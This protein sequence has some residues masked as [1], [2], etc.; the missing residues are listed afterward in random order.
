M[1]RVARRSGAWNTD[2]VNT[3][4]H[5]ILSAAVFA[6]TDRRRVNAAALAGGMLPDLSLY[7][8]G[9]WMMTIGGQSPELFFGTTYYSDWVQ[10]VMSVD[11]SIPL[12]SLAVLFALL[13]RTPAA[14][15]FATCGW[16]H[17][18]SDFL[19]HNDDARAQF[20]PLGDWVFHSP[21]SYWDP[22][23]HGDIAGLVE[24]GIVTVLLIVLWRR[25]SGWP[26]RLAIALAGLAQLAPAII[27]RLAF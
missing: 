14:I 4:A 6:R 22:A 15:A 12:W 24:I 26:A 3:P 27:W 21:V 19:L 25:F 17:V 7:L 18:V 5:L 23:H 10:S 1:R 9:A 13:S 11:N 20:W 2:R 8:I 16:M